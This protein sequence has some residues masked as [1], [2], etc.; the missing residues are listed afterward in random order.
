MKPIAKTSCLEAQPYYLDYYNPIDRG[1]VPEPVCDHI[2]RCLECRHKSQRIANIVGHTIPRSN[3]YPQNNQWIRSVQMHYGYLNK[4]VDCRIVR[5]FMPSLLLPQLAM[6]IQTPI[7]AH[8]EKCK[9]CRDRLSWLRLRNFSIGQLQHLNQLL[10]GAPSHRHK[11][12]ACADLKQI[13]HSMNSQDFLPLKPEILIHTM[14]CPDCFQS[15]FEFLE[16]NRLKLVH[17]NTLS[18]EC[19]ND[20]QLFDLIL[21]DDF[22]EAKSDV[23]AD[24]VRHL[25]HCPACYSRL[26]LLYLELFNFFKDNDSPKITVSRLARHD[27]LDSPPLEIEFIEPE[28]KEPRKPNRQPSPSQAAITR[29]GWLLGMTTAAAAA[30]IFGFTIFMNQDVR[31]INPDEINR[32]INTLPLLKVEHFDAELGT[33][34][35]ETLIDRVHDCYYIINQNERLYRDLKNRQVVTL[36]KNQATVISQIKE[37]DLRLFRAQMNDC[38]GFE[39]DFARIAHQY[40]ADIIRIEQTD[41]QTDVFEM[42]IPLDQTGS[43]AYKYRIYLDKYSQVPIRYEYYFRASAINHY[44]MKEYLVLTQLTENEFQARI[45][46]LGFKDDL[47]P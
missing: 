11:P 6:R 36:P 14:H 23:P 42:T 33:L 12:V 8:I 38:A 24:N 4:P 29:R 10:A 35:E 47:T 34:T 27:R 20:S 25:A 37:D 31:A 3:G 28:P 30:V 5:F 22:S 9:H 41:N 15:L 13:I 17:A 7:T 19:F 1:H 2:E 16:K 21:P 32:I 43:S 40:N 18:T 44:R 39:R 45:E 26:Q 46:A